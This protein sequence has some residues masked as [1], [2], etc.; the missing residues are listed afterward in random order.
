MEPID[1]IRK[2][3][4][5]LRIRKAGRIEQ[6]REQRAVVPYSRGTAHRRRGSRPSAQTCSQGG[7]RTFTQRGC[8]PAVQTCTDPAHT[9]M[10]PAHQELRLLTYSCS[11]P[12]N[13]FTQRETS[14]LGVVVIK[15]TLMKLKLSVWFWGDQK[16]FLSFTMVVYNTLFIWAVKPREWR[17]H[18]VLFFSQ[19][20]LMCTILV[21]TWPHV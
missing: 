3:V 7:A 15:L 8:R 11:R 14:N 9:L 1:W 5:E 21:H 20:I 6:R 19:F 4:V 12:G 16:C 13:R 2:F 18:S 10:F 17:Q